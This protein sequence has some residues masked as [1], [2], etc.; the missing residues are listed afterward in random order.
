MK[1]FVKAGRKMTC[2]PAGESERVGGGG[3]ED[4]T[5]GDDELIVLMT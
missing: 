1:L 4:V 2:L 5:S 3:E